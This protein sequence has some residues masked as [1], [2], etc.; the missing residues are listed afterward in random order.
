[1]GGCGDVQD[2]SLAFLSV[3]GKVQPLGTLGGPRHIDEA[4]GNN[5][6]GQIV[7][8]ASKPGTRPEP[9]LQV[10][11]LYEKGV[12]LAL[13]TP[14]DYASSAVRINDRGQIVGFGCKEQLCGPIRLDPVRPHA[15]TDSE[16]GADGAAMSEA[17]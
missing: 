6:R 11:F 14:A 12:K 5:D 16:A 10:A 7:G 15:V 1:V 2:E 13:P 8:L 17:E 4:L 3:H 9:G